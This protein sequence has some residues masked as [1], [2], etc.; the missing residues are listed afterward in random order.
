M[1][2][3]FVFFL[4]LLSGC[5]NNTITSQTRLLMDTV[6]GIKV[7]SNNR[8]KAQ[9]A[10]NQ[11]FNRIKQIEITANNFDENSELSKLNNSPTDTEIKVSNDLFFCIAEALRYNKLIEGAFDITV[12]PLMLMWRQAQEYQV[13]PSAEQIQDALSKTGSLNIELNSEK[14]TVKFKKSGIKIDLGGIVKGYAVDEAVNTLKNNGIKNALVNIGGDIYCLGK[15]NNKPWVLGIQ[16]PLNKDKIIGS[17]ELS[18]KGIS[19]AGGYER[20]FLIQ[21]KRF[22]HII[23][24]KTGMPI[25]ED[26]LSVTVV[27][28]STIE[29]D[30]LDTGIF[31][32]GKQNGVKVI[33]ALGN[34]EAVIITGKVQSNNQDKKNKELDVWVSEGLKNKVKIFEAYYNRL[35]E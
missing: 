9:E 2:S 22:G 23:N 19:T 13:I 32:L 20:F 31:V 18:D 27:A 11:A 4:L 26:V 10:I 12:E 15:N 6:C 29:T 5:N 25:E 1:K 16:D 21:G 24:P 17:M 33:E 8:A 28:A 7:V 14:Q 35:W 30:A 3:F 34:T